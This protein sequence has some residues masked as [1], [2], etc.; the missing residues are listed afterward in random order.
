MYQHILIPTDGSELSEKAISHAVALAKVHGAKITALHVSPQFH[1]SALDPITL[2][3]D[4]QDKHLQQIRTLA[5]QHLEVVANAARMAGIA[6]DKV[7]IVCDHLH[8][9]IIDTAN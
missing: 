8:E 2:V 9:A 3:Q 1:V 7:H 6:C 4:A 5:S